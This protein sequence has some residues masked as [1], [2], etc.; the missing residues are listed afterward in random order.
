M[1]GGTRGNESDCLIKI[2]KPGGRLL[3]IRLRQQE[4]GGKKIRVGR[5]VLF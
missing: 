2:K 1:E 4:G 3:A 5:K